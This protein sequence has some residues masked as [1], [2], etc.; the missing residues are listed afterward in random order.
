MI[1]VS[2]AKTEDNHRQLV[3]SSEFITMQEWFDYSGRII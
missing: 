2:T 3:A 1:K